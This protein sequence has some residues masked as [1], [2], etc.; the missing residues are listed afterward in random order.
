MTRSWTHRIIGQTSKIFALLAAITQLLGTIKATASMPLG[1][2]GSLDIVSGNLNVGAALLA[3]FDTCCDK[4]GGGDSKRKSSGDGN[5]DLI[6]FVVAGWLNTGAAVLLFGNLVI[7]LPLADGLSLIAFALE[8]SAT[9]RIL[10]A[11]HDASAAT[12]SLAA[13]NRPRLDFG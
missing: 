2:W 4:N 1:S 10:K 5:I 7:D 9:L 3:I 12:S 6:L 13:Q 11:S 8:G